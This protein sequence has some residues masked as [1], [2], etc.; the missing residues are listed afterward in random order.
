MGCGGGGEEGREEGLVVQEEGG[1]VGGGGRDC[2]LHAGESYADIKR[3][4]G[5]KRGEEM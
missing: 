3:G 2:D 1:P 4:G 5:Q